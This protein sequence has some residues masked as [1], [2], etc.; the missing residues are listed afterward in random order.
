MRSATARRRPA[1][2]ANGRAGAAPAR[3]PA[4]PGRDRRSSRR[5]RSAGDMPGTPAC[6][7]SPRDGPESSHDERLLG[8]CC[9]ERSAMSASRFSKFIDVVPVTR[10]TSIPGWAACS[11]ISSAARKVTA[12]ASLVA[13]RTTPSSR[14]SAP[15]ARRSRSMVACST[16]CAVSSRRSPVAV[17]VK[18]SGVRSK[19]CAPQRILQRAEPP[20]D[21][22]LIDLERSAGRSE[23][24]GA[25]AGEEVPEIVPVVPHP[26]VLHG[27]RAPLGTSGPA[28]VGERL[29]SRRQP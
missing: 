6:R 26:A 23:R 11:G 3:R 14:A 25:R 21:G 12:S 1:R 16:V 8:G 29:P 17:S 27:G 24:A 4:P 20:A 28:A 5:A 7:R 19:S 10:C 15:V 9:P 22:G 18:P 2:R 13:T